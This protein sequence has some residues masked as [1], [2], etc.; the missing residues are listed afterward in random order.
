MKLLRMCIWVRVC[1]CVHVCLCVCVCVCSFLK[2]KQRISCMETRVGIV[3]C[4]FILNFT[5]EVKWLSVLWRPS[6]V[7]ISTNMA[8]FCWHVGES[9][10]STDKL[11]DSDQR[12]IVKIVPVSLTSCLKYVTGNML[13]AFSLW[14]H[15]QRWC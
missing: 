15:L 6:H 7:I 5:S 13:W 4:A 1:V 11:F 10:V 9:I 8:H 2:K 3:V 14:Q 12:Q